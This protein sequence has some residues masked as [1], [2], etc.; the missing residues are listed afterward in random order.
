MGKDSL[1][2]NTPYAT[3]FICPIC[4][5]KPK[6]FGFQWKKASLGVRSPCYHPMQKTALLDKSEIYILTTNDS[7]FYNDLEHNKFYFFIHI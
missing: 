1:A 4:L 6:S 2:E 3:E 5:L 7:P